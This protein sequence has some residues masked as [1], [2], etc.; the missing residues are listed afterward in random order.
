MTWD[1][2]DALRSE[3]RR[4]SP[5]PGPLP[6]RLGWNITQ[7]LPQCRPGD[8]PDAVSGKRIEKDHAPRMFETGE[9][10]TANLQ[11]AFF[12]QLGVRLSDH[13]RHRDFT[14]AS[15]GSANHRNFGHPVKSGDHGFQL[16]WIHVLAAADDQILQ[17]V[18]QIEETV[19][20]EVT[21]VAG[22][23]PAVAN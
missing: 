7:H 16:S 19:L 14:P 11:N 10:R 6:G 18:N 2:W 17:T 13:K 12:G 22:R 4:G 8:F 23:E 1:E 3:P 9:V 20:V 21:D 5:R 15:V